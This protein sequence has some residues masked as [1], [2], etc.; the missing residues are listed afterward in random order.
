MGR[1]L[2]LL[3]AVLNA[4]PVFAQDT[5]PAATA[6][7]SRVAPDQFAGI[8]TD[9]TITTAG[10]DFYQYF[11]AL[12]HDKPLSDRFALAVRERPSAR[13]GNRIL[14]DYAN[15]TVFE[16]VLPGARGNIPAIGERAV[17]I[18]YNAVS[19]ADVK[20]LLFRDAD[21]GADEL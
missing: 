17:E 11:T 1:M 13:Q 3:A 21:L 19:D 20:R 14:I 6:A 16:A 18:A 15:R 4:A 9:Q 8:V 10:H 7:D 5:P 12:W 2:L